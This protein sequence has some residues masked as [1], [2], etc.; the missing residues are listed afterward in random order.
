VSDAPQLPAPAKTD[1]ATFAP[2]LTVIGPDERKFE[3]AVN[4][5]ANRA[6]AQITASRV[7]A[8]LDKKLSALE[9]SPTPPDT[10]ELAKVI[11]MAVEVEEMALIAYESR[12]KLNDKDSSEFE[13]LAMGLVGAAAHGAA[14]GA[15]TEQGDRIKRIRELGKAKTKKAK[16]AP[17]I[18][19]QIVE[20]PPASPEPAQ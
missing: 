6:Q 14:A 10:K 3:V 12:R 1:L 9:E 11:S 19:A 16:A 15:A 13:R 5:A 18:E 8:L 4:A 7:R 2:S 20:E 17:T